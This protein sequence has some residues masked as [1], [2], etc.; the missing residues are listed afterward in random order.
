MPHSNSHLPALEGRTLLD[1]LNHRIK[2]E[3]ASVINPATAT[4]M[5][6]PV[7]PVIGRMRRL[8]LTR[9]ADPTPPPTTAATTSPPIDDTAPGAFW[10]VMKTNWEGP[11]APRSRTGAPVSGPNG[12][13]LSG[14]I[15]ELTIH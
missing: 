4:A 10:S 1:E 8:R 11:A 6:M 14:S 7:P 13:C 12:T 2:N 15:S 3:L 5:A 9:M